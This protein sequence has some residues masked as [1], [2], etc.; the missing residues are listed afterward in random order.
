MRG[1]MNYSR[2]WGLPAR[3]TPMHRTW[4]HRR[5][6][7]GLLGAVRAAT[8]ARPLRHRLLDG[9]GNCLPGRANP[10]SRPRIWRRAGCGS[11]AAQPAFETALF[12][13]VAEHSRKHEHR[14]SREIVFTL[15]SSRRRRQ[16]NRSTFPLSFRRGEPSA[17]PKEHS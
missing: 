17:L 14:L 10:F 9:T 15:E 3:M 4:R 5:T 7:W 12:E 16:L 2:W 1:A 11:F 6:R 13:S 8:G